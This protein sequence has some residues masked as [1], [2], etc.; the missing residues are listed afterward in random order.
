MVFFFSKLAILLLAKL[1]TEYLLFASVLNINAH[2]RILNWNKVLI[3][4]WNKV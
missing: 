3:L 1:W 2:S 4:N